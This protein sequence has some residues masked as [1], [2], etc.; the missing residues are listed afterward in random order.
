MDELGK[1]LSVLFS[2]I[3]P[4]E[5]VLSADRAQ[6]MV[7]V[8]E[9]QGSPD[10][11]S[12]LM[13]TWNL[14]GSNDGAPAEAF[15]ISRVLGVNE[16]PEMALAKWTS[17]LSANL[18]APLRVSDAPVRFGL[19]AGLALWP[20]HATTPTALLER[21]MRALRAAERSGPG[22]SLLWHAALEDP[23]APNLEVAL[24]R[25]I[26]EHQFVLHYQPKVDLETGLPIAAEALV[27]WR[28]PRNQVAGLAHDGTE[29]DIVYPGAF[30]H[31]LERSS[32]ILPLGDWV[33]Q[34]ACRQ[35]AAWREH[36]LDIPVS[37]NVSAQ[38][39]AGAHA[40]ANNRHPDMG[41][42]SS[43]RHALLQYPESKLSL[44]LTETASLQD[45]DRAAELFQS[46]ANMG[47]GLELDDFGV[48]FSSFSYLRRLPVG[49]L[50]V[51]RSFVA[52]LPPPE[53]HEA[54]DLEGIAGGSGTPGSARP[55]LAAILAMGREMGLGV[56]A[57][58]VEHTWQ[59]DIL[60]E[61]GCR[62]AQGYVF[63]RPLDP[64]AFELWWRRRMVS[65][66]KPGSAGA[67]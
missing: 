20:D 28:R 40:P 36:G 34:E 21:A 61:L 42:L 3:T 32:L 37:V 23:D 54:A 5:P 60:R 56:V 51:D 1:R 16:S 64:A 11:L 17:R 57:E 46:L 14:G 18:K 26:H 12:A 22:T 45:I 33:I 7:G 4:G 31:L 39:V 65:L 30:M 62:S 43:V 48:G 63:S 67:P 35:M 59:A 27:R 58:G 41:L 6:A 52:S 50:K 24:Q 53:G 49:T 25:A 15:V 13:F 9:G 38:Q 2:A 55:I 19:H 29:Y 44:E 47:V 66:A 10:A 8:R